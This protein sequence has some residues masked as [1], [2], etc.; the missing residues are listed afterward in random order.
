MQLMR[1]PLTDSDQEWQ[2]HYII[3]DLPFRGS[4]LRI[5]KFEYDEDK[6]DLKYELDLSALFYNDAP[7]TDVILIEQ[8][9]VTIQKES[10][11]FVTK[12]FENYIKAHMPPQVEQGSDNENISV[13]DNAGT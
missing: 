10:A 13:G 6:L 1:H 7:V 5:H 3:T 11:E 9:F 4:M 8:H 12:A 2:D